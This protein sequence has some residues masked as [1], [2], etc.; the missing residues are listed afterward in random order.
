[1]APPVHFPPI[2]L[3]QAIEHVYDLLKDKILSGELAPGK[4]LDVGLIC[5]QLGVSRTPVKNALQRLYMQGLVE[6]HA[7]RA[8]MVAKI[9]PNDIKET[10]EL[11][12]ALEGLACELAAGN[13]RTDK[14]ETLRE[15]NRQMFSPAITMAEHAKLNNEFHRTIVEAAG[16]QKLLSAYGQLHAHLQIARVHYGSNAWRNRAFCAEHD[17]IIDALSRNDPWQARQLMEAHIEGALVRLL[18][19]IETSQQ[20]AVSTAGAQREAVAVQTNPVVHE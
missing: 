12:K 18:S 19:K 4:R 10:F 17:A 20:A 7:R 14:I 6:I 1:M 13:L 5:Q 8:T 2:V 11:R 3:R 16:N 9:E 15:L